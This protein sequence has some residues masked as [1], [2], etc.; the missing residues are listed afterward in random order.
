MR[1]R[2][3]VFSTV[4]LGIVGI[5]VYSVA[6]AEEKTAPAVKE[7]EGVGMKAKGEQVT[8]AGRISCLYCSMPHPDKPCSKECCSACIKSGDAPALVGADGNMYILLSGEKGAQLMTP[9]K[10]ELIGGQV[11]VKGL[12]VK[13]KGVQAIYV[14]SLE[15]A[16]AKK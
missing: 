7:N 6:M 12:L 3:F 1:K 8:L 13:Q 15:K 10:M 4:M 5:M 9:A 2:S 14:D 11:S 16:E